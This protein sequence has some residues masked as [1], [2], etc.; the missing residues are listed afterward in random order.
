MDDIL[1]QIV[2]IEHK[3]RDIMSDAEKQ[4]EEIMTGV[5][6]RCDAIRG[7]ILA[8][9]ESLLGEAAAEAERDADAKRQEMKEAHARRLK[10]LGD[11]YARSRQTFI[12]A[13]YA[14]IIGG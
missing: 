4:R 9:Q 7:E 5:K 11:F 1:N 2:S 6:A 8:R 13:I 12:D 3:A 14:D 10:S